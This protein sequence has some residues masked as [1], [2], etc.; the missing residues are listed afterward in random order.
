MR[1]QV[2][3]KRWII[4]VFLLIIS[5]TF[6]FLQLLSLKAIDSTL[7]SRF[8]ALESLQGLLS[9]RGRKNDVLN[10]LEVFTD[11]GQKHG[12]PL[13]LFHPLLFDPQV[14]EVIQP[15]KDGCRLLCGHEH[16]VFG[17]INSKWEKG[18]RNSLSTLIS[19]FMSG[20]HTQGFLTACDKVPE[21][22]FDSSKDFLS[23]K[24]IL[25]SCNITKADV[26]VK[27]VIFY[28]RKS[29]LWRGPIQGITAATL[30]KYPAAH[31]R[32]P[33]EEKVIDGIPISIPA[34]LKK[35]TS[36][37]SQS[38]FTGCNLSNAQAYYGKYGR[39]VSQDAVLFK[40][41]ALE[42]LSTA[43]NTLDHLG[44]R[45][46]LSSGTCLGWFRQCDIIPHSKD[47]D[48]GIW[49]KDYNSLLI[50]EFEKRGLL[51]KH[52]FG[53]IDDSFELS[54]RTEEDYVKLDIFFFYEEK[55]YMW[56]GGTQAK[57]GKK[58]K[59]IFPKFTLCWTEFLLM[60]VRIPCETESYIMANYGRN[61][62]IPIKE[63]NWKESPPNVRENG[64]WDE[65]DWDEVIQL[66]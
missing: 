53:Q 49:I 20:L 27:L 56:N 29:Y 31:T 14:S 60:K 10:Q 22:W 40:K 11:V 17:V 3:L 8:Q 4:L 37:T 52:R 6:L 23:I 5:V 41:K 50:A 39:D 47:V 45:F 21:P 9:N 26:V 28:D 38:Q 13:F 25:S 46:W 12:A 64:Q 30:F 7:L 24:S 61:W 32:F 43:I 51:L 44:V 16:F 36:E 2:N 35:L 54:F 48:L 63:W 18:Q 65:K 1:D 15:E 66:F 62:Q 59:Y 34:D 33:T 58:F 19:R 55:E 57:T 42:V